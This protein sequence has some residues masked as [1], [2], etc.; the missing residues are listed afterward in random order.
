[1]V[2]PYKRVNQL[3]AGYVAVLVG[4]EMALRLPGIGACPSSMGILYSYHL[5]ES[6]P[7]STVFFASTEEYLR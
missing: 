1:M 7:I 5:F 2:L 4:K 6:L 3:D